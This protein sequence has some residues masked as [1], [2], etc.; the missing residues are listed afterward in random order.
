MSKLLAN[1]IGIGSYIPEKVFT[2]QDLARMVDT[3]DEWIV[4][5]TGI[6]ERHIAEINQGVSDLAVPAITKALTQAKLSAEDL[7]LIVVGTCSPDY[8]VF[9]STGCVIQDRIGAKNAAAFDVSAACSGFIYA[10]SIA[11]QYIENGTYKNILVVGADELSK[12]LN[13]QDRGTCVL[14]GDGAGAAV[15]APDKTYGVL[16]THLGAVGSGWKH[17]LVPEGGTKQPLTKAGLENKKNTIQ[18]NGKEVFRFAVKAVEDSLGAVLAKCNI[19]KE[20][21]ALFIPHQANIRIIDHAVKH[22]GFPKDK[23]YANLD[24][25]GNTSAASIPLA[26]DEAHREGRIKKGDLVGVCGFGA[27]L[28]YGAGIIKWGI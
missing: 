22:M 19:K 5:R 25:Y 7:E 28:T 15:L 9:P 17:L 2:N 12:S 27:G 13:W 11:T 8:P 3:T 4:S 24:R 23:V 16:A 1:I 10:L 20:A 6:K 21:L 18:M 14:F 26:L